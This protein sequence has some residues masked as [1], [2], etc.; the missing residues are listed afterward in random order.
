MLSVLLVFCLM[1]MCALP[2]LGTRAISNTVVLFYCTVTV[3]II[4]SVS[5]VPSNVFAPVAAD[6]GTTFIFLRW[7]LPGLPNGLLTGFIL[8]RGSSPI[9]TGVLQAYNVTDLSVCLSSV[10]NLSFYFL[11]SAKCYTFQTAASLQL[12]FLIFF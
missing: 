9:Y 3:T 6:I 10:G 12:C 7:T 1:V 11:L 4:F 8:Y 5:P 2:N